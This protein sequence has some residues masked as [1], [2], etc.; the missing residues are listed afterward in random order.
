MKKRIIL[1][2]DI[3]R[4]RERLAQEEK[5]GATVAKYIRD[6]SAFA[7]YAEGRC[8][9]KDLLMAYKAK[10]MDDGY[11]V[12][13]V[14][15]MLVSINGFLSFLGWGECRVKLLRTQRQIYQTEEKELTKAEY[16]RLIEA[17][18]HNLRLCLLL[19]TICGT[20]IRVSELQHFT[21]EAVRRNEIVIFCKG[22]TR[23]IFV[24]GDLKKVAEL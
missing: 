3:E 13:S 8:V 15:S 20:G 4:Y 7:I 18:R 5:S 22:K 21:V 19:Q 11:A 1:Q 17:S 6:A 16:Y 2:E 12:R 24:P 23:K 10:L 14:N 9:T